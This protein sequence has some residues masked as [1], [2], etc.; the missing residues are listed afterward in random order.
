MD[1]LTCTV[2][3]NRYSRKDVLRRHIEQV[4]SQ[5][6]PYKCF[7]CDYHGHEKAGVK[8]HCIRVHEMTDMEFDLRAE[9]EY[10]GLG[11]KRGRPPKGTPGKREELEY[12]E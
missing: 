4:H 5:R 3:G 6:R 1:G 7:H 9:R 8:M 11:K 12:G 10:Q 2:C